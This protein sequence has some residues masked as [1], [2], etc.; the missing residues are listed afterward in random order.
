MKLSHATTLAG[1]AALLCACRQQVMCTDGD[2]HDGHSIGVLVLD[3]IGGSFVC[4]H[5]VSEPFGPIRRDAASS[6][7]S[8]L[9]FDVP[10]LGRNHVPEGADPAVSLPRGW[11]TA[12][13]DM[14]S[15]G[16]LLRGK[17]EENMQIHTDLSE[18]GYTIRSAPSTVVPDA[19]GVVILQSTQGRAASIWLC[20]VFCGRSVI[21]PRGAPVRAKL[22]RTLRTQIRKGKVGEL[23][24]WYIVACPRDDTVLIGM[25]FPAMC[26]YDGQGASMALA[27]R[28]VKCMLRA[29]IGSELVVTCSKCQS[30]VV[31]DVPHE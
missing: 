4:G 25:C 16:P 17:V 29:D 27:V 8:L 26:P 11:V 7:G 9:V 13:H 14:Y 12:M 20:D 6:G 18:R 22:S 10:S 23:L 2:A 19:P 24:G 3:E 1:L 15:C 31:I 21:G 30:S 5:I 28:A